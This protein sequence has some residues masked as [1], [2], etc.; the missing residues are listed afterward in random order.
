M[1]QP[2]RKQRAGWFVEVDAALKAEFK[3]Y[4]SG[5]AA[6]RKVTEAAIKQAIRNAQYRNLHQRKN[7][8]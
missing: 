6:M 2:R 5:R 7:E 3:L 4:Y 8:D 1:T